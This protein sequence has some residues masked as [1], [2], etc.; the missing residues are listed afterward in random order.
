MLSLIELDRE[1]RQVTAQLTKLITA[2]RTRLTDLVDVGPILARILGEVGDVGR[3]PDADRV[4]AGAAAPGVDGPEQPL[5]GATSQLELI[6][7]QVGL[8]G[9]DRSARPRR[10]PPQEGRLPPLRAGRRREIPTEIRGLFLMPRP[11]RRRHRV[12]AGSGHPRGRG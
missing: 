1:I 2:S 11:A 12:A 5:N 8:D 10:A 4:L 6:R 3:F 9:R 7:L